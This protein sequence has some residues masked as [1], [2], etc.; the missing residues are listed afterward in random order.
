MLLAYPL[1][2]GQGTRLFPDTG[3][4]TKLRLVDSEVTPSGIIVQAY[5]P[6]GRPEYAPGGTSAD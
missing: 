2:L 5:R 1:V 6:D 4:D 3:R